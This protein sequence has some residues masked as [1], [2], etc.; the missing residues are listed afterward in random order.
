MRPKIS[1]L[2]VLVC[3]SVSFPYVLANQTPPGKIVWQVDEQFVSLVPQDGP[4]ITPENDHP[5]VVPIDTLAEMIFVITVNEKKSRFTFGGKKADIGAPLF[6]EHEVNVL[7][8]VFADALRSASP[9]QDILFRIHGGKPQLGG[10]T[11]RLAI[12]TGRAFWRDNRLHIIFGEVQTGDKT[13][14]IFGQKK[15]DTYVRKFGSR[16]AESDRVKVVFASVP[17]ITQ[18]KDPDD[19]VRLDWITIDPDIV[20]GKTP[21]LQ[22]PAPAVAVQQSPANTNTVV[23]TTPSQRQDL[24]QRLA[25]LK[26]LREEGLITEE[27]YQQKVQ[28]LVDETY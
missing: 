21:E 19:K 8:R 10:I 14:W 15:D 12:N 5:A 7:S 20:T 4:P 13:K 9:Q 24:K 6:S 22:Q 26:E 28:E 17:G 3:A 18:Y 1:V 11:K 2:F 23:P 27:L 16:T 25:E